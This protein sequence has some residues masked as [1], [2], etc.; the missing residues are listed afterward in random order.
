M[1]Q[2]GHADDADTLDRL[3]VHVSESQFHRC[4]RFIAVTPGGRAADDV[5]GT[6]AVW[7]ET[8][9]GEGNE[10]TVWTLVR[11]DAR[12]RGIGSALFA[13]AEVVLE[14]EGR[15]VVDA[16]SREYPEPAAG[17]GVLTAPTGAGRISAGSPEARF[18]T[19]HGF[20]LGQ[21]TRESLLSVPEDVTYLHDLRDGARAEAGDDYVLH[22]WDSA[23]DP[24]VVPDEFRADIAALFQAQSTEIPSGEI[25]SFEEP[26]DEARLAEYLDDLV[27][28]G[29]R[30]FF[31]AVEYVGDAPPPKGQPTE[32]LVAFTE[33]VGNANAISGWQGDMLVLPG[34]RGHR[35]GLLVL[36]EGLLRLLAAVPTMRR[37]L[38]WNAQENAPALAISMACGFAP[39]GVEA[40]W[41]RKR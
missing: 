37:V 20:R 13:H 18:L 36:S 9:G 35:L 32:R 40:D 23:A 7:I 3:L 22:V 15:T 11:P 38:T 39:Y 28:D 4:I 30:V 21:V 10:A 8:Q 19:K 41:Q 26:W 17:P 5:L 27:D 31:I 12:G 1:Q 2:K 16:G 14:R 24:R 33:V 29:S 25:D 34:H 6:C